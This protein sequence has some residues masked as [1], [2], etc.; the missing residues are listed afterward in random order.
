MTARYVAAVDLGGSRVRTAVAGEDGELLARGAE[1][2]R[3]EASPEAVVQ[4]VLASVES[5]VAE[6]GGRGPPLAIGVGVP[7]TVIPHEGKVIGA[8]NL[9]AWQM[10]SVAEVV[11]RRWPIPVALENDV[12]MAALGEGWRGAAKDMGTFVFVAL[13]TGVG[14]GVIIDGRLHRG[15]RGLGGEV[16]Y[17]CLGREH[18]HVDYQPAGCLERLAGGPAIAR[19]GSE[20]VGRPVSSEEVFELARQGDVAARRVVEET[21]EYLAVAFT[22]IAALLDPEAIVVGGGIGQQGELLL[23]PVRELV[24]KHVPTR[25]PI[26]PSALGEDAQLYGAVRSALDLLYSGPGSSEGER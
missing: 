5:L 1:P 21:A 4:S 7:G 15:A 17:S 26:V 19:R 23:A 24:H 13:G 22:N 3:S 6:A 9:P 11:G 20:A 10:V 2:M 25:V 18:L 8:V 16:C 14:G 12:N